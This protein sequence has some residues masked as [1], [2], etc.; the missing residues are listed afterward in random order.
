MVHEKFKSHAGFILASVGAAVGLGDSLRFPGLCAKYG[1]G[2]FLLIY[3]L[4]MIIIGVP[5]LNAEIA[6]GRKFRSSTPKCFAYL[7]AKRQN[8]GWSACFNSLVVAILY[9]GILSWVIA[10]LIKIIPLNKSASALTPA[11]ISGYFFTDILNKNFSPFILVMLM[12]AWGIMYLFLRG[13]AKSLAN[14]AKF[15]VII[16]IFLLAFLAFRGLLFENSLLALRAL[17]VPNFY[18]LLNVELWLDGL[19][20]VFFSLSVLVGIMPTYGAYLPQRT[21]IFCDSLI[22]AFTDFFISLLSSIALFT[23]LYGCGLQDKIFGSGLI[24]AFKVYPN[25]IT[26]LFGS[27]NVILNSIGGIAFYLSLALMALQSAVSMIECVANP[28]AEKFS[29]DKKRVAAA[30]CSVGFF[31]SLVFATSIGA[32]VLDITDHFANY[33]NILLLG[34]MECMLLGKYSQKVNL[35]GEINLYTN[36]LKLHKTPFIISLKYITPITLTILASW[37]V[38]HFIFVEGCNYE[39]YPIYL[40]IFFGWL[41]SITV[42]AS[43]KILA[44]RN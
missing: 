6:L 19:G 14:T 8:I 40:Q 17:F 23:T 36:R 15:T 3:F 39:G 44:M 30:I 21:N 37:G 12:F 2:S 34:I 5:I 28:I 7:N 35:I 9:A 18:A 41:V 1:G 24:T 25:A 42:F 22:I 10:M 4:G 20:Q 16:P 33:F 11:Q 27:G 26:L 31:I 43:G 29:L 13:G 32:S 38:Y